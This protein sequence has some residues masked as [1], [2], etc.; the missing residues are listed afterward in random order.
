MVNVYAPQDEERK[1]NLWRFI[2]EFMSNN[3]GR[4]IIFGDFNS[5]RN[6]TKR[7]GSVFSNSNTFYF[8][9][10]I[11]NGNLVDIPMGGYKFTRVDKS[12]TKGIRLDRFLIADSTW[13]HLGPLTAVALDRT[14][15]DHHPILLRRF[16]ADY[17]PISFK[18]Y[19]T[20]FQA[21]GFNKVMADFWSN[22]YYRKSSP[23]LVNFKNKLQGLKSAIKGW[24]NKRRSRIKVFDSLREELR[25]LDLHIDVRQGLHHGGEKRMKLVNE[26]HKLE[27]EQKDDLIQKSQIKWCVD[28]DE[29]S[30][31][32]HGTINKKRKQLSV[33]GIK[34]NGQWVE[35]PMA[36]KQ[37][38]LNHLKKIMKSLPYLILLE[39]IG[40]RW[41]LN[42][43]SKFW[44]M[45]C[46]WKKLKKLFGTVAVINRQVQTDPVQSA[47]I[48]NRH[49]LDRPMILNE[50]VHT[51]K[52]K[53]KK[54]MIFKV[55]I[56]K[57]Y[58][59]LTME[60]FHIA[61]EDAIEAKKFIG[62]NIGN[63]CL[64]HLIYA[65][66][67][68]VLGEWSQFNLGAEDTNRKIHW[69]KWDLVFA[70]KDCGRLGFG[71]KDDQYHRICDIIK[72]V[73]IFQTED[74]WRWS[75]DKMDS[76]SVNGLRKHLDCLALPS[77]NLATRWN[78]IVPRKV[79][80]HVWRLIKDRLPTRFNLWFR[81]IDDVSLICA[82]CNNGLESSYHTMS[83]CIIAIKVWKSVV[84]WL[85]L[86]LPF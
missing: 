72:Q 7:F 28:G 44:N 50:V 41:F 42:T 10:F 55:D 4:Y 62:I 5:V 74:S 57:A 11:A 85:N 46:H 63:V 26:I 39:V 37:T 20:W 54:A 8:N 27:R 75:C 31:F 30:K 68:I 45:K 86:N 56:A 43:S 9:E 33:R 38:F 35:E 1:Q 24:V 2:T 40:L 36:V 58:D 67:V 6:K 21:D 14:I 17:G 13:N 80:I 32:F 69:V 34:S 79:N 65:D 16:T 49:I 84:K 18:I 19:H 60:G 53:K 12:C 29:N 15:S 81:G 73:T 83:K 25:N 51:L 66:D 77:H 61:M 71:T 22:G 48:K 52:M 76:F 59:T 64:S 3:P 82:V 78:K 23:A 70:S 47:F